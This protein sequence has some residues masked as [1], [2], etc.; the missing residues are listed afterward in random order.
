MLRSTHVLSYIL[1][2]II[3]QQFFNYSQAKPDTQLEGP[4]VYSYIVN[5]T[6]SSII[7]PLMFARGFLANIAVLDVVGKVLDL[8]Y[9]IGLGYFNSDLTM[10]PCMGYSTHRGDS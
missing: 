4:T 3:V 5:L 7:H 2:G 10:N 9:R 1:R 8:T 6:V